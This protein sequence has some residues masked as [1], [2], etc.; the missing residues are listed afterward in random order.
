LIACH[1]TSDEI[2]KMIGADTLGFLPVNT[3]HELIGGYGCCSACFDGDYP[4]KIPS[5]TRKD[6]FEQKL[7]AVES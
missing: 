1:H 2:A 7:S 3:L 5:D 6:R 4:T